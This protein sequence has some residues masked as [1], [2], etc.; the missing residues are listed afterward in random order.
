MFKHFLRTKEAV[1]ERLS[2]AWE[3][4]LAY[5]RQIQL[6]MRQQRQRQAGEHYTTPY[7]QEDVA[8]MAE[9]FESRLAL[10]DEG[11]KTGGT[12]SG[13]LLVLCSNFAIEPVESHQIHTL[14]LRNLN[15]SLRPGP[16]QSVTCRMAT[17]NN[18]MT[19]FVPVTRVAFEVALADGSKE[20]FEQESWLSDG[21][22]PRLRTLTGILGMHDH[23]A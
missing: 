4:N 3:K 21:G 1:W 14:S 10:M 22:R 9:G 18:E 11:N 8:A 6:E 19:N 5:D 12:W 23:V 15:E 17:D 16:W 2:V 20:Q 13:L 7:S